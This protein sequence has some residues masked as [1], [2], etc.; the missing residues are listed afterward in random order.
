LRTPLDTRGAGVYISRFV[1][2]ADTLVASHW[3]PGAL[4]EY[5][6]RPWT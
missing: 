4:S 3:K 6:P 1:L 2:A 5:R